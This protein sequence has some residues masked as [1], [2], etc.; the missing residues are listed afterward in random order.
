[1][2]EQAIALLKHLGMT[3]YEAKAY[4]ALIK[5]G[6]M[7]AEKISARAGIPLP[8]VYDT[9][10]G[11]A[12]RGLIFVSKTRPQTYKVNNP[13]KIFELL[14][15]DE[16]KKM[17]ERLKNI[18]SV[19]PQFLDVLS[20][21]PKPTEPETEEVMAY[22]KRKVNMEMLWFEAHSRAKKD[23]LI[24]AGDLSWATKTSSLIKK[25]L[26][27]GIKYRILW[28]KASKDVV[29]NVKKLARLGVELRYQPEIGNLR[30]FIVDGRKVSLAE[31][32]TGHA[33][34][35][36]KPKTSEES[37]TTIIITNRTIVD[38]LHKYFQALWK[39]SMPADRFLKRYRKK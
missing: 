38:V 24:F 5:Y 18:E 39:G 35:M 7:T 29:P 9:M 30:G 21:V 33:P 26:K 25:M 23:I 1:M 16:K 12:G 27:K 14:K 37:Y 15:S 6:A 31:T 13:K 32:A 10:G 3:E 19:V 2:A 20:K 17:Q 8:R 4:F 28:C 34:R 22:I 11:L 36:L